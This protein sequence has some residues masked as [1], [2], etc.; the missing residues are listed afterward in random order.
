MDPQS[1]DVERLDTV[2][3][4]NAGE[5]EAAEIEV[6]RVQ[7]VQTRAELG[8]TLE[9][10][11]EKL[12]PH[13][14]MEQ[15]K[16]SVRE[17]TIG[18]AQD[19]VGHA[20]DSVKETASD[21]ADTAREAVRS[22]ASATRG[23][24]N[25]ILLTIKENPMPAALTGLG[26][27]W[28]WMSARQQM[29]APPSQRRYGYDNQ[30]FDEFR[31]SQWSEDPSTGFGDQVKDRASTFAEQA[32]QRAAG[33][34]D[35]VQ[36]Q[37]GDLSSRVQDRVSEFSDRVQD[38]VSQLG[39]QVQDRMNTIGLRA[40]YQARQATDQCGRMLQENPMAVG[41]IAMAL[42]AGLG[43]AV[44]ATPQESRLMGEARDQ[45]VDR[46]QDMV[47]GVAQKAQNA[48]QGRQHQH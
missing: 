48:V 34:V 21:V 18:R 19:A 35:Q 47:Q 22:A 23:A 3:D 41:A 43:F 42:G 4:D 29:P 39:S 16:E 32:K 15:A 33:I 20:V 7:I 8:D 2:Y 40:Q 27:A 11:K 5:D 10:I 37:V 12:N 17:A 46:A 14:L 38:Q 45:F 1:R 36:D 44:P 25:I 24:G 6:T 26:L 28:L 9:A 30:M 13:T 31:G